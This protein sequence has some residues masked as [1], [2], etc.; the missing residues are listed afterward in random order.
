[1]LVDVIGKAGI[2]TGANELLNFAVV[3]PSRAVP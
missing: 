1:M 3:V 2:D